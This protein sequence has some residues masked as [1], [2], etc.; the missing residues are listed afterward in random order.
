MQHGAAQRSVVQRN[1]GAPN[2]P[3]VIFMYVY[4]ESPHSNV[5]SARNPPDVFSNSAAQRSAAQRSGVLNPPIVIFMVLEII[6]Y[7]ESPHSNN[8]SARNPPVCEPPL[9]PLLS[10]SPSFPH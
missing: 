5:Y 10:S 6:L 4:V 8:Y 2:P 3:I 7:V 1:C 9:F